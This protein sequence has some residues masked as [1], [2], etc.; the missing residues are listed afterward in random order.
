MELPRE[1]HADE[2]IE[3]AVDRERALVEAH[4]HDAEH[5]LRALVAHA[6]APAPPV[7]LEPA[8]SRQPRAE[9]GARVDL[10]AADVPRQ[11]RGCARHV[12]RRLDVVE[13]AVRIEEHEVE[14]RR[15]VRGAEVVDRR[16]VVHRQVRAPEVLEALRRRVLDAEEH[17]DGAHVARGA[18]DRGRDGLGPPLDPEDD[19][20]H[21]ARADPSRIRSCARRPGARSARRRDRPARRTRA[22]RARGTRTRFPRRR[23]RARAG[24]TICAAPTCTPRCCSSCTRRRSRAP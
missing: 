2:A 19:V 8:L 17:V 1:R 22:R 16:L 24:D 21:A 12:E 11:D 3:Q 7:A 9:R 10:G 18:C 4:A 15:D 6:I 5:D 23:P 14:R 13:R 20:L